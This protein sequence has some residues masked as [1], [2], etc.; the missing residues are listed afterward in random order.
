M[1]GARVDEKGPL[2]DLGPPCDRGRTATLLSGPLHLN[3]ATNPKVQAA[4]RALVLRSYPP[5]RDRAHRTCPLRKGL[6]GPD[7]FLGK[8]GDGALFAVIDGLASFNRRARR[9][10]WASWGFPP[11]TV[12]GVTPVPARKRRLRLLK[13]GLQRGRLRSDAGPFGRCSLPR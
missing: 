7:D 1:T 6:N 5:W 11:T 4:R 2:P 13:D 3:A 9:T 10:C 12:N 8:H